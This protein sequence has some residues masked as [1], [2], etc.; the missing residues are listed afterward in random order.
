MPIA[1]RITHPKLCTFGPATRP[2]APDFLAVINFDEKSHD[3]GKV[4]RTVPIPLPGNVGNEPHHCH[5]SAD[6]NILA[7]GGL[8]SLL[9]AQ[10]GIFFF[11]VSDARHPK[12][13]SSSSGSRSSITDDF[14][15]CLQADS[16]S[17]RWVRTRAELLVA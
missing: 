13:L 3:Y 12:F 8:L 4:I 16:W 9:R 14:F 11:D 6:K 5:L 1:A 17:P 15:L 7:C 2:I 10:N